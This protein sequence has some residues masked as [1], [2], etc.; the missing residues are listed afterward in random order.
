MAMRKNSEA[1]LTVEDLSVTIA[2]HEI[3]QHLSIAFPPGRRTAIIGPNGA[4]KTTLPDSTSTIRAASAWTAM[5]C[6]I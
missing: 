1:A 5:T 3:L 4:G 6:G 2:Q